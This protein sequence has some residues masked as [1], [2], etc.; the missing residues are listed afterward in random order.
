MIRYRAFTKHF[1]RQVAVDALSLEVARGEVVALLGPNGSGKTTTLKA[2]AGLIRP[3]SGEVGLGEPPLPS[4]EAAARRVL[5]FLPQKV[6]FPEALTGR[7]VVEFYRRLRGAPEERV[8]GVLRFASLNGAGERPV[9]TYSG[10]MVQRLG[11]AVALLPEAPAFLLDEPTAALD[12][13][14]LC[15]FYG[16]V[17]RARGDGRAVLFT[18]HQ[19]G[20][21]ERLADRFAV[22]VGGRLVATLTATEL[23]DRLAARGVMRLRVAKRPAGLLA[24]VQAVAPVALWAGDELVVPGPAALRPRVLDA[25][26]KAGVEVR[27]LTAEEGRLDTL[28]RELVA[29]APARRQGE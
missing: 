18:S 29:E 6:A 2:A 16:L 23:K 25:V 27:G 3:T 20:D 22:L 24:A 11:L 7:E 21:A 17:E 8:A 13:D 12:P 15:A 28:Y 26:R 19:L 1:G 10:G 5:S 14:G 4:S 9:G